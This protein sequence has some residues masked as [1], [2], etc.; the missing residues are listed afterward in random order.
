MA[1]SLASLDLP[2]NVFGVSTSND[3]DDGSSVSVMVYCL[4]FVN[5][6][7]DGPNHHVFDISTN[8]RPK[9]M[10]IMDIIGTNVKLRM[11]GNP[12]KQQ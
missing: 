8:R 4:R 5:K 2:G 6:K 10:S 7:N 1:S 3:N 9:L 11:I 12:R